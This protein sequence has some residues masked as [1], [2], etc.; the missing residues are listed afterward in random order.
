MIAALAG[1]IGGAKLALGL[2]SVLGEALTVIVN[3]GDDFTHLGLHVSPDLDTV[4]YTLAGR[5]DAARGWGRAG[6]TWRFMD[7]LEELGGDTWFNLGDTDLA[8]NVLRTDRLAR[9]ETLTAITSDFCARLGVAATLLPMSDDPVRTVIET[10]D[11]RLAFQDYFVRLRA[12]P[13]VRAIA[14]DGAD[15]ARPSPDALHALADPDLEA[16]VICPS[17]PYLSIAPILAVPGLRAAVGAA[18]VPVVAVSPI[19][20]G[21]AVKGPTAKIMTELGV[22]PSAASVARHY[23][24]LLDGMM[25]DE[26]DA[27][28]ADEIAAGGLAVETAPTLMVSDDDKRDLAERT[29]AFARSLSRRRDTECPG[30]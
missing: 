11:G 12:R 8:T 10:P 18:P 30:S 23:G 7:A 13:V 14:F 15:A 1:G 2:Q 24:G 26:M 4:M 25:I 16:V 21:A 3:T 9:G 22:T 27:T 5:A 17:N 20:G 6:E 28:L 29:L 19:I